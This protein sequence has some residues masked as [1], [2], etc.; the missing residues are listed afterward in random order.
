MWSVHKIQGASQWGRLSPAETRLLAACGAGM[1]AI[2]NVPFGGA[3]FA[4]EVFLG[5]VSLP[6]MMPLSYRLHL[7]YRG[8]E[9]FSKPC[10]WV[11]E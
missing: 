6:L 10:F 4:T 1:G 11:L 5:N 7:Q 2:Y 3:L 8:K 9:I